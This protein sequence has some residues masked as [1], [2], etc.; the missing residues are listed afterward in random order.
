MNVLLM[1][2]YFML[3]YTTFASDN[4]CFIPQNH[5]KIIFIYLSF[6]SIKPKWAI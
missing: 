3:K 4:E 2:L 5:E 6:Y 1:G